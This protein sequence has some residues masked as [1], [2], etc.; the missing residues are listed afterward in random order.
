[1]E[2]DVHCTV[3]K[4]TSAAKAPEKRSKWT[5]CTQCLLQHDVQEERAPPR[6]LNKK[7]GVNIVYTLSVSR[8]LNKKVKVN[9]VYTVWTNYVHR[10]EGKDRCIGSWTKRSKWTLCT[11]C[12][13]QH[14][15]QEERALPRLLNKKV[16]VNILYTYCSLMEYDGH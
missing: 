12:L 11:H 1:M 14:D 16:K 15:V 13:L 6:L 4:G 3:Q 10:T 9:I 5:L 2:Y 8:L 7:V